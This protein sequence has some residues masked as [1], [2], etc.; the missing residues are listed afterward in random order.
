MGSGS[1]QAILGR[2]NTKS[3]PLRTGPSKSPFQFRIRAPTVGLVNVG[4]SRRTLMVL[5]K[6]RCF[7]HVL[8]YGPCNH[9]RT[10]TPFQV[11][12]CCRDHFNVALKAWKDTQDIQ[13]ILVHLT[14]TVH[15]GRWIFPT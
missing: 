11:A 1:D 15:A 5:R 6:T 10:R 2:V 9:K 7:A 12:C 13:N 4:E 8:R 3:V 14:Y